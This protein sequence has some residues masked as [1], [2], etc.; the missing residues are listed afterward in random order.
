MNYL[1]ARV[2]DENQKKA[3]P[4]QK[5]RLLE[6][7]DKLRWV[8]NKDYKYVEFDESAFHD[9]R[10][11]FR[12]LVIE[13][14]KLEKELSI[15]CFDKI[16]RYSRDSSSEE[17]AELTKLWKQGRIEM[18]F[19]SDNLYIHRDSPA[20]DLF[21]LDIGIALAGYYSSAIRDNVKRR[22]DQ[23]VSDGY[24]VGK[25]PIGYVNYIKGKDERGNAIKSIMLDSERCHHIVE[26][27]KLRSTGLS[28]GAIAKD[29]RVAGLTSTS[30]KHRPVTKAKWEEI[31][32]NPF[33]AGQMRYMGKLY[34][35]KYPILIEPWLWDKCQQVKQERSH[36]HPKYQGKAFLLKKLK[37][38]ECGC[39]ITFDGPKGAGMNVYGRCTAFTGAHK[40]IWVNEKLLFEQ[41]REVLKTLTVPKDVLP[42]IIKEIENNH[43]SEQ[44]FYNNHK[45]SLQAE[46]DK[47]DSELKELFEDR[48]Q[49]KLRPDIFESMVSVKAS[50]QKTILQEL[51][52]HANGN[53][54]FLIGASY[55]LDVCSRA[56]EIFDS[57]LTSMESRRFLL[58]F[59]FS[60]MK[61]R[62][63]TME[64]PLK[65]PF[66][67][68][69]EMSKT[70]N[71]C[72]S[73]NIFRNNCYK[74]IIL[75]AREV[76]MAREYLGSGLID[77]L[78]TNPLIG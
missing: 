67:A 36:T 18:H 56:V 20:A 73:S 30:R 41:I 25:A 61:L 7:A 12:E 76:D 19:P 10:K 15:I 46:Y 37:C 33:Y 43:A 11:K 24:W 54:S 71:W 3:L 69:Q 42:N 35:H 28:Y 44:E 40:A 53:K 52:D 16:D 34:P 8:K 2:S 22:F 1:I 4:A 6:Y 59:I 50:R 9:S 17:K 49:F 74:S 29:R 48:K 38:G 63:E 75:L 21:R 78:L 64:L 14:L 55:I 39:T 23:M 5:K 77:K 65:Q 31:L 60:N 72:H 66:L 68:V 70:Q 58:D 32:K 62:G 27:F 45:R 13:P 47:L 57:P 51:E 26:G